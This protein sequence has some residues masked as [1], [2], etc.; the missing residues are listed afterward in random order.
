MIDDMGICYI[1]TMKQNAHYTREVHETMDKVIAHPLGCDNIVEAVLLAWDKIINTSVSEYHVG[2]DFVPSPQLLGEL[3]HAIIP[4]EIIK[5]FPD[6]WKAGTGKTEKDLVFISDDNFSIEIKTSSSE[7][8][9]Y[10]NRS[11]AKS[12]D[13][14]K[15][16]DSYFLSVNFDKITSDVSGSPSVRL[17]RFGYLEQSDWIAQEKESGQQSRLSPQTYKDKLIIIYREENK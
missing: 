5:K 15:V 13:G 9:I 2:T 1:D 16:K 3:L 8:S 4:L 6:Q 12:L 17:I 14:E 10:A 7:K 11:Y